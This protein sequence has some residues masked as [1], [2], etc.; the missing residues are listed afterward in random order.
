MLSTPHALAGAALGSLMPIGPVGALIGF[1]FGFLSH[2]ILDSVPHWERI[3]ATKGHTELAKTGYSIRDKGVYIQVVIDITIAIGLLI[4]FAKTKT[5]TF[6]D[7]NLP[8][9]T[10]GIGAVLPD[11]LDNIHPINKKLKNLSLFK[12]IEKL[13]KK[14]HINYEAQRRLPKF[15]GLLTQILIIV[16]SVAAINN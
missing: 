5:S 9:L 3:F 11:F 13:H 8:I 6:E 1:A 14:F 15:A 12:S 10:A 7:I 16:L 4:Y 2:F